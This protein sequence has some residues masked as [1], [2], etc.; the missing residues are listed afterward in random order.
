[1]WGSNMRGNPNQGDITV[2]PIN[3]EKYSYQRIFVHFIWLLFTQSQIKHNFLMIIT[4]Y[5]HPHF[6]CSSQINF[7]KDTSQRINNSAKITLQVTTGKRQ[8]TVLEL[9]VVMESIGEK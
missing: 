2:Q 3:H 1:M 6:I 5:R 9:E 7:V 8:M 4:R